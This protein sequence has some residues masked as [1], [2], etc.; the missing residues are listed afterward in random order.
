MNMEIQGQG[1][2]LLGARERSDEYWRERYDDLPEN[3]GAPDSPDG[4]DDNTARKLSK[5]PKKT[6]TLPLPKALNNLGFIK[7]RW[8]TPKSSE[9]KSR[10]GIIT[11]NGESAPIRF[12]IDNENNI[13][14]EWEGRTI[15]LIS[16]ENDELDSLKGFLI[17]QAKIDNNIEI[18][19]PTE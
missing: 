5:A 15:N 19:F 1:N 3:N 17:N 18:S 4:P 9:H 11:L 14:L 6:N 2:T 16:N 12:T 10:D 7:L 13:T 8:T